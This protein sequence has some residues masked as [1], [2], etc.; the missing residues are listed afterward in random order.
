VQRYAML[1]FIGM[2]SCGDP[3]LQPKATLLS[4]GTLQ[5]VTV[6]RARLRALADEQLEL[7]ARVS[8][9]AVSATTVGGAPITA[10]ALSAVSV[11]DTAIANLDGGGTLY[12]RSAG[13]TFIVWS[14]A[15]LND[16]SLVT[17]LPKA[18]PA[19]LEQTWTE[20]EP[21]A[22][23][24]D[25]RYPTGRTRGVSTV[26]IWRVPPGGDLQNALDS[27]QPGD[28][29]VL[30]QGATFTG[31]Y[32]LPPKAV[33][34]GGWIIVRA[35]S[36]TVAAGSRMN[37]DAA[38]NAP[39][40]ITPNQDPAI[41]TGPAAHRWRLVGFEIAHQTGAIYNYGIVVLGNGFDSSLSVLPSEIVLDRMYIHGS[42]TDGNSR[43]VAFNG[44]SLAVIDSWLGE[45][46]AKGNDSQ[47]VAGWGGQ[48]P[49][50]IENNHIEASGQAVMFGG[51]DPSIPNLSPSDITIRG[52]YMFKPMSWSNGRWTVKATFELKHAKRVLFEGNVL[53]NHWADA[54]V[55]YPILIQAVSQ[56]NRAPWSTVT[57]VLIQNNWIR[58]ATAGVDILSR[59]NDV[60]VTP[61]SRVAV[62]NNLFQ[63]VGHDP[64]TGASGRIFQ[65]LSDVVDVSI[66][67]NTTTLEG[68]AQH[69]VLF[70]GGPAVR[71]TLL[72][73]IF[74]ATEYG[75]FGSGK[76]VGIAALQAFA[77]ASVVTGNA[78]PKQ[79]S[80][81][82]PA[83]NYF[84]D[85]GA[86]LGTARVGIEEAC[87][88]VRTWATQQ[89]VPA[90]AG[91]DCD[92]LIS[93]VK[94]VVDTP[95]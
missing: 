15:G 67:N 76:G 73:N 43:C 82:Y 94:G 50:L 53:E 90:T 14:L 95:P 61:T 51:A 37:P 48:G 45:C 2:P 59:Y 34:N 84:P 13:N 18:E 26:K 6:D 32:L 65:L 54:Q 16:S 75:V 21:P 40:I 38:L 68:G 27:A 17:V 1:L 79:P 39:K 35:E 19:R 10:I 72:N 47:G 49:F 46:H 80:N 44:R 25:A 55:G 33:G 74:P 42:L 56:D 58:N 91:V 20:P 12:A 24:V 92:A 28:E 64:I 81:Q 7:G 85:A 69:A 22:A 77:P 11:R 88:R 62:V 8:T 4:P 52:N 93:K 31:N 87:S 89:S 63:D 57:D 36:L 70:D 41:R 66:V 9:G 78:F 3:F 83:N 23:T 30:A 86:A 29:I 60:V 5:E 71:F